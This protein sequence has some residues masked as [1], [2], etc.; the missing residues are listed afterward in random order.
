MIQVENEL[1][2]KNF[3]LTNN[4]PEFASRRERETKLVA[5]SADTLDH[6]RPVA[7]PIEQ[8]YLSQPWEEFSLRVRCEYA[9]DR[10]VYTATLKDMGDVKDGVRERL[11]INTP[12]SKEAFDFYT[13]RK[14]YPTLKKLRA[15]IADGVTVDYTEGFEFPIV[16]I[17]TNDPILR[18]GVMQLFGADQFEDRTGDTRLDSESLAHRIAGP[19][20]VASP[21]S[22]DAFSTRIAKEMVAQYVTGKK[23]VVT[24]LTGMSG[25]GKTTVTN[26]IKHALQKAYGDEF[27]PIVV[28]TDD[29]HRGKKWL[30]ASYGAPWTEWD[31]PR[32]YNTAA[33]AEDLAALEAGVPLQKRHFDFNAEEAVLDEIVPPSPFVIVEGLYA[34][35]PDLSGVRHLHFELPTGIATSVGRDVRRIAIEGRANRAFPDPESRLKYQIESALPLYLKQEKPIRQRFSASVRPLGDR[36]FM[37]GRLSEL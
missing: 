37:L 27:T 29:Y 21:E 10:T 28:S 5:R 16:E 23:Q 20:A 24:G 14:E 30:E 34:G 31:D 22:L 11:E 18:A 35:S 4:H 3:E 8:T 26:A 6:Y 1:N 12:I 19:E 33:L 15:T 25:S 36:A 2:K 32:V 7:L 9:E 13:S 17:E